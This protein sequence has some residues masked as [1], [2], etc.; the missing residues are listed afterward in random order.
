MGIG[1]RIK[2][3]LGQRGM[4]AWFNNLS[5]EKK[6]DLGAFPLHGRVFVHAGHDAHTLRLTWKLGDLNLGMAVSS[7]PH[8]AS[9]QGHIRL[10]GISLYLTGESYPLLGKLTGFIGHRE[11]RVAIH[12]GAVWWTTPLA[13]PDL[14]KSDEPW[15]VRGCFDL[16]DFFLGEKTTDKQLLIDHVPVTIPLDGQEYK[17]TCTTHLFSVRR[18]RWMSETHVVS[19]LAFN[20]EEGKGIPIPGKGESAHDIEEDAI[21]RYS[22]EAATPTDAVRELVTHVQSLRHRRGGTGW[23]PASAPSASPVSP[24]N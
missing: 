3:A 17:G 12:D 20:A 15:Y 7:D 14:G 18:P 6:G 10:P 13:D 2:D 5:A 9:I 24:L 16:L 19:E 22:C 8:E 1:K 21:L 4:W 23:R 11:A